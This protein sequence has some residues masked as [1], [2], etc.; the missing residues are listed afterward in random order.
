MA[1]DVSE[2]TIDEIAPDVVCMATGSI[3]A[4]PDIPGIKDENVVPATEVLAGKVNVGEKVAILGG[5]EIGLE[6]GYHL[7][8]QGKKV[9]IIEQMKK[10]GTEMIP[11]F[12]SYVR[13][14]FADFGGKLITS[15]KVVEI[16]EDGAVYEKEGGRFLEKADSV[17]IALGTVSSTSLLENVR[18]KILETYVV[19]DAAKRGKIMDAVH[20][21][22]EIAR[23]I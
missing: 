13:H 20:G 11:A 14:K 19:G 2:S 7:A 5:G 3:L 21:A 8:E 16:T 22:A 17:V 15:A 10:V 9:T 12:N 18:R 4:L 6:T 23:R 1:E